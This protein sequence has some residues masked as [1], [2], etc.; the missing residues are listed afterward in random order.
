MNLNRRALLY[1]PGDDFHKIE[2]ATTLS[3]DSICMDLEDGVAYNR[4]PAARD[5]IV[6][7]LNTLN[8]GTSER[9]V[10]IN[11]VTSPL[12]QA[13]LELILPAQPDGIVI[14]KVDNA[15]QVRW[16]S[17]KISEVEEAYGWEVGKIA[18]LLIVESANGIL[19]LGEISTADGR[20]Q[21]LIFGAEDLAGDIGATRTP[22]AT[23]VFYARSELI[24]HAKAAGLQ[25]IDMVCNDFTNL[26]RLH[27]EAVQG[28][29]LGYT[30][31]QVIHPRQ[32]PVVHE[33]FTP[34]QDEVE[35]AQRLLEAYQEHLNNGVGAFAIDG[36]L[37]D[38]PVIRAAENILKRARAAGK[39]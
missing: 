35:K 7:A 39:E 37:I 33:V 30:G 12:I 22:G 5:T 20:L 10:R 6:I 17:Q 28:L 15:S 31:K 34:G 32:I 29:N 25:A 1:M 2:K 21:A 16:A 23:E 9:L 11:P 13:D 38:A 36:I 8:Y 14:P 24:L 18:L 27:D 19:N 4:K 3:V 26:D